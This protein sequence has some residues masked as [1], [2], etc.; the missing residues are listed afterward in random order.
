MMSLNVEKI[1]MVFAEDL[2]LGLIANTAGVFGMTL[3]KKFPELVDVDVQDSDGKFHAGITNVP[4]PI[5]KASQEYLKEIRTMVYKQ[6][7]DDVFVV[8]FSDIA[9]GANTYSVYI[10][11]MYAVSEKDLHYLGLCL[12]GNKKKINKLTGSL[13]LLR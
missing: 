12:G 13:P 11:K 7:Y 6:N 4:I 3:G 2:P 8:D 9:Q 5:L 1:V 10:E